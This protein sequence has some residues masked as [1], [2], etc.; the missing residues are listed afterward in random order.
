MFRTAAG[1]RPRCII[2]A[3][4][5]RSQHLWAVI[6]IDPVLAD[7][8]CQQRR[9]LCREVKPSSTIFRQHKLIQ[10]QTCTA[11][12]WGIRRFLV[13]QL[14]STPLRYAD[15]VAA[16]LK[17]HSCWFI[18]PW[19]NCTQRVGVQAPY[20]MCFFRAPAASAWRAS[21]HWFRHSASKHASAPLVYVSGT[22]AVSHIYN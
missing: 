7:A 21:L 17:S 22:G 6:N 3:T 11:S 8:H 2:L 10:S 4:V 19:R 16:L 12:V 14:R 18:I 5:L 15:S 13:P 9:P 1:L 20:L